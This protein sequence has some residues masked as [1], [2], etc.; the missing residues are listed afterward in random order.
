MRNINKQKTGQVLPFWQDGAYYY[1]K[2]IEAYQNRNTGQAL[3]YIRRAVR[4]EPEEPVFLCQLAIV[5]AEKGQFDEANEWLEKVINDLDENMAECYFFLANNLAH[6]GEFDT[7]VKHLHTYLRLDPKGDFAEDAATLLEMLEDEEEELEE[8]EE[9]EEQLAQ[10]RMERAADLLDR[11]R[12]EE[13]E[14]E[15]TTSLSEEPTQWELYAYMAEA[16]HAQGETEQAMKILSD[17]LEKEEAGFM[18]RCN[19]AVFLKNAGDSRWEMLAEGLKIARPVNDWHSYHLAKTWFHLGESERAFEWFNRLSRR[20]TFSKRP[21][22]YHQ[23]AVAAWM[24]GKVTKAAE[25][26]RRVGQFDSQQKGFADWCI[27]QVEQGVES[28]DQEWF[29]YGLSPEPVRS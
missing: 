19:A 20:H 17:L 22:F 26:F 25:L 18:A 12:Y 5:L 16:M 6:A 28:P 1:K 14:R 27:R 3:Q 24:N 23:M 13:A 2:G 21:R 7:A 29:L 4:I 9:T 8:T 10:S 11:G 15:L